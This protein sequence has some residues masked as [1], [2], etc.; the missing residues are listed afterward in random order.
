[1]VSKTEELRLDIGV[2]WRID[3][4]S[5]TAGLLQRFFWHHL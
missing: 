5:E 4:S 3:G 1:V 2:L